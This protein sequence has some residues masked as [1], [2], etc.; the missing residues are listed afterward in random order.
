MKKNTGHLG[1]AFKPKPQCFPLP[2]EQKYE[3]AFGPIDNI[4][5]GLFLAGTVNVPLTT[6]DNYTSRGLHMLQ[7]RHVG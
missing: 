1:F 5:M 2:L 6:D 4:N 3:E 7:A